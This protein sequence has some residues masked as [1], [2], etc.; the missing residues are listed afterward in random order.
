M[1]IKQI[2]IGLCAF[3]DEQEWFEF[4]ENWYQPDILGEYLSLIHI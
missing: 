3:G 1:D 2:I 4:K